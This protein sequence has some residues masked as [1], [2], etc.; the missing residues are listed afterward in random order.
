MNE[1]VKKEEMFTLLDEVIDPENQERRV[2]DVSRRMGTQLVPGE[3]LCN[4]VSL[5]KMETGLARL[6]IPW[7]EQLSTLLAKELHNS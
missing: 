7:N 5:R 3:F 4:H 2:S 1:Q 6:R